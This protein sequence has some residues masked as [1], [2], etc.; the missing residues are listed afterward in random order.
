MNDSYYMEIAIEQAKKAQRNDEVPVGAVIVRN[1]EVLSVGYNKVIELLDPTAHAEI[2]AIKKAAQKICN[3]RL[4][5]C[6]LYVTL[7]PCLM[8]A[9]SIIQSRISNLIF[10]A[11][12]PKSGVVESNLKVFENPILNHHTHTK[13]GVLLDKSSKLLKDFFAS[14]RSIKKL[15]KS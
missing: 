11:Y 8:C 4:V 5:N 14:K 6:N 13:G 10:G 2:I 12:D 1:D 7:E 15:I 3:Y 9:G